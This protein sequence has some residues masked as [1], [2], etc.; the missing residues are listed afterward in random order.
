MTSWQ[1]ITLPSR[2]DSQEQRSLARDSFERG[3]SIFANHEL[4]SDLFK[5]F[6]LDLLNQSEDFNDCVGFLSSGST[7][8]P[9]I[10]LHKKSSLVSS[11]EISLK[12]LLKHFPA[13]KKKE[14]SLYSS[15]PLFHV[16]GFLNLL[17]DCP[18]HH[19]PFRSLC[20]EVS[21]K[22][23]PALIVGVPTM[24]SDLVSRKEQHTNTL[25]Y[26]GG[27]HCSDDLVKKANAQGIEVI[28]T[29]GQ[30]ESCGAIIHA[31]NLFEPEVY[32]D[33]IVTI[34]EGLLYY[35]TKRQAR[36]YLTTDGLIPLE[37]PIKT[38]DLATKEGGL[39]ILGRADQ[40]IICGGENID[41][42]ELQK[43]LAPH[44][45]YPFTIKG[46]KDSRLGEVPI[47]FV[48]A[49]PLEIAQMLQKEELHKG[50][51]RARAFL[52]P[53]D[54]KGIK[55]NLAD[56]Q[57]K[58]DHSERIQKKILFIPGFM[59]VREE[60]DF[61]KTLYKDYRSFQYQ[62]LTSDPSSPKFLETSLKE[63][64]AYIEHERP[65]H[66]Y[67]YSMG[68]RLL[69]AIYNDLTHRPL[70]LFIES[71]KLLPSSEGKARL[72]LDQERVEMIKDDFESFLH[73][74]YQ[75]PLWALSPS[76]QERMWELKFNS[77]KDH[78]ELLCALLTHFGPAHLLAPEL[79]QS[80]LLKEGPK[81]HYFYGAKDLKYAQEAKHLQSYGLN[82]FEVAEAGH[83]IH[84]QKPQK[85]LMTI[86]SLNSL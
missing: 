67:A 6:D 47:A 28:R 54:F 12:H 22:N 29:Y 17:R 60:G 52:T 49:S 31:H 71:S 74:W 19:L 56:Y 70:T 13:F 21:K 16:G 58:Y 2:P 82:I 66:I 24:L 43:K 51:D 38:Q 80:D 76:E 39:K 26:C 10:V 3:Y 62:D 9:K 55:P 53:P 44:I 81:V 34:K 30:T 59:G 72:K 11:A 57:R 23:S 84:F 15:L 33:C 42:F 35:E 46:L 50:L 20:E 73:S 86:K 64:K 69:N 7:G 78:T 32:E 8:L 75:A 5:L 4:H 14:V 77:W 68:A 36:A 85:Q 1:F 41:L 63:L 48:E 25:F 79:S 45:P 37:G 83:N 18:F 65:D 27:G 40:L 61:L